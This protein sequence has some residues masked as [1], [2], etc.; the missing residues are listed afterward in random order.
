MC[1]MMTAD[2][3]GRPLSVTTRSVALTDWE[4]KRGNGDDRRR[5]SERV[6][7]RGRPVELTRVGV[8]L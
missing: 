4:K 8:A 2:V 1:V 3:S 7:G 6:D 5:R